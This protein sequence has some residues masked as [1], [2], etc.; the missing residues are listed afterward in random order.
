MGLS[1]QFRTSDTKHLKI[2]V[3]SDSSHEQKPQVSKT[4]P[5]RRDYSLGWKIKEEICILVNVS[6]NFA[7]SALIP[8]R[9][10]VDHV[11]ILKLKEENVADNQ[12]HFQVFSGYFKDCFQAKSPMIFER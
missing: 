2:Q 7:I 11:I 6:K 10:S 1:C 3:V 8:L 9:I 12:Q 4:M 5:M